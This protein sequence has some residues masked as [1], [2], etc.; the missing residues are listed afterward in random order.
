MSEKCGIQGDESEVDGRNSN[1]GNK[2]I[3]N[4]EDIIK[5]TQNDDD[6]RNS[7]ERLN[8]D[9]DETTSD[10]SD[11]KNEEE[12][13]SQINDTVIVL[14]ELKCDGEKKKV[15]IKIKL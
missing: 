13:F 1:Q 8:Q 15:M 10:N 6:D 3:R 7:E 9:V 14:Q 5:L 12:K 11:D 4:N 2:D